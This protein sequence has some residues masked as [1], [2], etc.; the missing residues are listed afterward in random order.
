MAVRPF[1]S[2]QRSCEIVQHSLCSHIISVW[3]PGA[4]ACSSGHPCVC[5][6]FSYY[7]GL[8]N[9][10]EELFS[11]HLCCQRIK[12]DSS[13]VSA[14]RRVGNATAVWSR[15][16]EKMAL[17]SIRSS[18]CLPL[19]TSKVPPS[20]DRLRFYVHVIF[21]FPLSRSRSDVVQFRFSFGTGKTKRTDTSIHPL[22]LPSV[23]RRRHL[24]VASLSFPFPR[25]HRIRFTRA[26]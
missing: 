20:N 19:P 18:N 11:R 12:L 4:K 13:S 15:A 1:H 25:K 8:R 7:Q 6:K 21:P 26:K 9:L 22:A 5:L 14:P 2:Q 3:W 23:R 24:S 16:R 10:R 17:H